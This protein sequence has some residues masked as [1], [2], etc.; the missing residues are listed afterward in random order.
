MAIASINP[1]TGETIK[2]FPSY[3]AKEL[4]TVLE[5]GDKAFRE[6]SKT[7]FS[8]RAE[9]MRRCAGELSGNTDKYAQLITLE[10]GKPI[11]QAR[12]EV[13][14]CALVCEYYASHAETFLEDEEIKTS[15]IKS[16]ISYEP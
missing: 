1:A 13:K 9:L 4:E 5:K 14:K 10:M 6:W 15:A 8:H 3:T 7:S 12:A 16:L 2:T 11:E